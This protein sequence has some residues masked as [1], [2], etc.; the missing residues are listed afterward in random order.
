M[1][2]SASGV[3]AVSADSLLD[4]CYSHPL[5]FLDDL[6]KRLSPVG[7]KDRENL[8]AMKKKEH[9]E[10]GLPFDGEFYIWD[11]RLVSCLSLE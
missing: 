10:L 7:T 2:K 8:L 9:E 4:F 3:S 1:V 11:Y 6:E 5:K